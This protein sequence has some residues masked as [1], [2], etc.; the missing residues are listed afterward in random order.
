NPCAAEPVTTGLSLSSCFSEYST[1][2]AGWPVGTQPSGGASVVPLR[3]A[4]LLSRCHGGAVWSPVGGFSGDVTTQSL[5][6][7]HLAARPVRRSRLRHCLRHY[8]RPRARP[9][10]VPRR[11]M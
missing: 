2:S 8:R 9:R 3:A 7:R 4:S 1:F 10:C 11:A 5:I 6:R